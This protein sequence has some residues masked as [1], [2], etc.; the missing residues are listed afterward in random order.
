MKAASISAQPTA[1]DPE[2]GI[3]LRD[4]GVSPL[5]G[6]RLIVPRAALRE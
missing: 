1:E 3:K 5:E 6:A 2:G 4:A